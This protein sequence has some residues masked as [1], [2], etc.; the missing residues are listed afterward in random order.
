MTQLQRFLLRNS[1]P[2]RILEVAA[3]EVGDSV[4]PL[5][6]EESTLPAVVLTDGRTLHRPTITQLADELGI[7]ELPIRR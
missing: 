6:E 4:D 3:D 2:H 5:A 7:T 1:Y